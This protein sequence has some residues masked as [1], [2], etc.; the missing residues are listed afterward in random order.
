LRGFD[1]INKFT[2]GVWDKL[3]V[4]VRVLFGLIEVDVKWHVTVRHIKDKIGKPR[5]FSVKRKAKP[6]EAFDH[7]GVGIFHRRRHVG[8]LV[9]AAVNGLA[10]VKGLG[11]PAIAVGVGRN[12]CRPCFRTNWNAFR[13]DAD[14]GDRRAAR[15]HQPHAAQAF[16]ARPNR[17]IEIQ[18]A[19]VQP[20]PR[21]RAGGVR[22]GDVARALALDRHRILDAYRNPVERA[23]MQHA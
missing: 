6:L 17:E 15:R 10:K 12:H 5:L 4:P 14:F 13:R 11:V 23:G 20:L 19:A 21:Y 1:L 9:G 16:G 2:L 3:G 8:A 18:I 7:C 22:N